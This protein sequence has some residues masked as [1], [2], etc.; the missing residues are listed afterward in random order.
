MSVSQSARDP[1]VD[2]V[3]VPVLKK[4]SLVDGSRELVRN[5]EEVVDA[6]DLGMED[7]LEVC[8]FGASAKCEVD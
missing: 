6:V 5:S 8:A 1:V 7:V 3:L 4:M 2:Q